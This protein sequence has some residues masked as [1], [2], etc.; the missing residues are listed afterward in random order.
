MTDRCIDEICAQTAVKTLE[1]IHLPSAVL[2]V[3]RRV[4]AVNRL[5]AALQPPSSDGPEKLP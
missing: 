3:S 2:G 5:M 1:A 4:L